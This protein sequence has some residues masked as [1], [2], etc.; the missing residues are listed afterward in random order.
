MGKLEDLSIEELN[1]KLKATKT[2]RLT[3]AMIFGVV[4]LA[5]VVLGYWHSNMPVFISTIVLGLSSVVVTSVAP[6]NIASEIKRRQ[7]S[8]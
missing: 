3:V 1:Q 8:N 7:G 6:L 2:I 5:S 4:I